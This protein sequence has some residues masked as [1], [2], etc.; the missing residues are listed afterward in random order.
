M[1]DFRRNGHRLALRASDRDFP[2]A[3]SCGVAAASKTTT[4]VVLRE[5][6]R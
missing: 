3:S 2:Q 1:I 4:P 6:V 5:G